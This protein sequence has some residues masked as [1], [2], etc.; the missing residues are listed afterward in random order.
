MPAFGNPFASRTADRSTPALLL[1]VR[2]LSEY[3]AATGAFQPTPS[4]SP[5]ATGH[6]D[7]VVDFA[8]D[9][10]R[11]V[12]GSDDRRS[13]A[14]TLPAPVLGKA[15]VDPAQSCL[16]DHDRGAFGAVG[17]FPRVRRDGNRAGAGAVQAP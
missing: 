11:P 3:H 17:R 14:I 7:A 10:P 16:V 9:G 5:L 15:T 1:A 6:V 8:R 12:R 13:A 2:D 4:A